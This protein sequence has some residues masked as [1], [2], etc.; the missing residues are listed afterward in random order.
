M[1]LEALDLQLTTKLQEQVHIS[2]T[3][4][5]E[6]VMPQHGTEEDWPLPY[7]PA[8]EEGRKQAQERRGR[9][10]HTFGNLTLLSQALNITVSNGPF[11]Q[12]CPAI[13]ANSALRLNAYFQGF[14]DGTGWTE[15]AIEERGRELFKVA[16]TVWPRPAN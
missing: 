4:N 3:M 14:L 2:G 16:Q 6:H 5:I 13:T 12:K 8:D 1:F 9:L 11:A 10:L 15:E 7:D